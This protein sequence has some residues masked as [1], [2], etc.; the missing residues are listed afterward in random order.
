[1]DATESNVSKL[2]SAH[3]QWNDTRGGSASVWLALMADDVVLGSAAGGAAGMEFTK[4]RTGKAEAEAYFAGLAADWELVH[5]TPEEFV[6]QGDT[7]VVLSWVAFRSTRTG[8]VAESPK[9][10]VFHFR[11][12]RITA[13]RE[14]FDT[15]TAI[16]ATQPG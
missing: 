4:G 2:R 12:G 10:D 11:D 6:A 14:F 13:F 15:H 8:K 3:Q 5:F 9:A 7:V 16:A 1:M